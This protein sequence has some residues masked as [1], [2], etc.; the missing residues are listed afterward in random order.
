M[1]NS[2][3]TFTMIAVPFFILVGGLLGVE[4]VS[5]RMMRIMKRLAARL[6][7]G[8]RVAAIIGMFVFAGM[9]GSKM[10]DIAAVA[11]AFRTSD[12]D[13]T[14]EVAELRAARSDETTA[15]V[16][17]TGPEV[18][19]IFNASAVMGETIPP[20]ISMLVLCSIT[21]VSAS[22]LFAG[23]L[24]PACLIGLCLSTLAVGRAVRSRR[25]S[26]ALPP[27]GQPSAA[28]PNRHVIYD[29]IQAIPI[30]G[31]LLI[32]AV[33]IVGGYATPSEASAIAVVYTFLVVCVI[34]RVKPRSL[35]TAINRSARLAGMLLF[36]I[37][38]A[39]AFSWLLTSAG[40]TQ[41]IVRFA[42]AIGNARIPFILLSIVMLAVLGSVFEGMPALL[43]F[44]PVFVPEA[45]QLG[46]N[47]VQYSVVFLMSLGVGAFIPPLGV[48]YYASCAI[49]GV[50][51]DKAVKPTY[52]YMSAAVVGIILV[53]FVPGVTTYLPHLLGIRA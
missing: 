4:G 7:G 15:S 36:V 43:I 35:L 39:G 23:G 22:A 29:V 9:S 40:I 11:P 18:A 14:G 27:T 28:A 25:K 13:V 37:A 20:S 38:C 34:Y 44:G 12:E 46:I 53:G 3:I 52:I 49:T 24:L 41:E 51:P 26:S 16:A 47:V 33:P 30:L 32:I 50:D 45:A 5:T 8:E 21:T 10:A 1:N 19:S 48:G 42:S 6:A 31:A 2:V 17:T